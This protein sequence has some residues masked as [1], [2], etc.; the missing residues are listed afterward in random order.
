MC[1]CAHVVSRGYGPPCQHPC[2]TSLASPW[3]VVFFFGKSQMLLQQPR[4]PRGFCSTLIGKLGVGRSTRF[5]IIMGSRIG[6]CGRT[7]TPPA[8]ERME[9]AVPL[10]P[11]TEPGTRFHLASS[12]RELSPNEQGTTPPPL[13]QTCQCSGKMPLAR[14]GG[15]A[16]GA[17]SSSNVGCIRLKNL[18]PGA[19]VMAGERCTGVQGGP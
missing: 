2:G 19:V 17:V 13:S 5:H 18:V 3:M 12:P 7:E 14:G 15:G 1:P 8:A 4:I 11:Y 16:N 10:P 6:E 9:M